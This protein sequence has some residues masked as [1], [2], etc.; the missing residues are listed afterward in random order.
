MKGSRLSRCLHALWHYLTQAGLF[1]LILVALYVGLGRQFMRVMLLHQDRLEA[2][3]SLQVGCQVHVGSAEGTWRGIQP[4]LRLFKVAL[5]L[6]GEQPF[7]TLPELIIQPE[8][9]ASL[10]HHEAR[11]ALILQHL[12]LHLHQDTEGH[13]SIDELAQ[14]PASDTEH[15]KAMI[16]IL[17]HQPSLELRDSLLDMVPWQGSV[18]QVT[19]LHIKVAG[20]GQLHTLLAD[21][22]VWQNRHDL[23]A[24]H[25]AVNMRGEFAAL[26]Q[27]KVHAYLQI[28]RVRLEDFVPAALADWKVNRV[29]GVWQIWADQSPATGR[30]VT[31][32]AKDIHMEAKHEGRLLDLVWPQALMSWQGTASHE[33]WALQNIQATLNQHPLRTGAMALLR[34]DRQWRLATGAW[35]L[36]MPELVAQSVLDSSNHLRVALLALHPQGQLKH[37]LFVFKQT[38]SGIK[39]Q[40]VEAVVDDAG[41]QPWQQLPGFSHLDMEI[42]GTNETGRIYLHHDHTELR[43]PSYLDEPVALQSLGAQ[44]SWQQDIDGILSMTA[45]VQ[46]SNEDARI[47]AALNLRME[48]IPHLSLVASME[49]GQAAATWRYTPRRVVGNSTVAWLHTAL[50]SGQ[51]V[52]GLALYEGQIGDAMDALQMNFNVQHLLLDYQPGWPALKEVNAQLSLSQGQLHLDQAQAQLWGTTLTGVHADLDTRPALMSLVLGGLVQGPAMDTLRLFRESPLRDTL[53]KAVTGWTVTGPVHGQL[54]LKIPLDDRPVQVSVTA[55]LPGNDMNVHDPALAFS[56]VHGQMHFDD[57][58]GLSGN[59]QA[60]FLQYPVDVSLVSHMDQGQLQT[61]QVQAQGKASL[62]ALATRWPGFWWDEISGDIPFGLKLAIHPASHQSDTLELNSSL[63]GMQSRLPAPLDKLPDQDLAISLVASQGVTDTLAHLRVGSRLGAAMVFKQGQLQRAAIRLG[64]VNQGWPTLPGIEV[65][66]YLESLDA[67]RWQALVAGATHATSSLPAL[68]LA[69]VDIRSMDVMGHRLHH[70]RLR[71][72]HPGDHWQVSLYSDQLSGNALIPDHP[73]D[74]DPNQIHVAHL[75][76]PLEASDH[77][78]PISQTAHWQPTLLDVDALHLDGYPD[79]KVHG[80]LY[81]EGQSTFIKDLRWSIPG[82]TMKGEL[83]WQPGQLTRWDATMDSD[84]LSQVFALFDSVPTLDAEMAHADLHIL[85]PGDPWQFD[86]AQAVGQGQL[87]LSKG[88]ILAVSRTASVSRVIGLFNFADIGR[89]LKLD[90]SDLTEKGV[91][92]DSFVLKGSLQS[93]RL[94]LQ[95]FELLGPALTA[96]GQGTLGLNTHNLDVDMGVTVPVTRVFPLAL[97][98]VAGPVVGG[99]ALAAQAVLSHPLAKLTT[100]NYHLSGSWDDP[101]VKLIGGGG[102][103]LPF[104]HIPQVPAMQPQQP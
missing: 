9:G 27:A 92:F 38:N 43:V 40:Y 85:W 48:A 26:N 61:L 33:L 101:E 23:G 65:Q 56:H 68:R 36:S 91:A 76:W 32:R 87:K 12:H 67:D 70:V 11:F 64:S 16:K 102:L 97:A 100:V 45:Q 99:A 57:S 84:D 39:I 30:Q 55:E 24:V 95:N 89:R 81:A 22:K 15:R 62:N 96:E 49:Q 71:T 3:L 34:K 72:E 60:Q 103:R 79:S 52:H 35:E 66:G 25:A 80:R 47:Q 2:F 18:V 28:P 20:W 51:V 104:R 10:W 1:L 86:L 69:Q 58:A 59:L 8:L 21:G 83:V 6:P 63:H 13:W 50:K 14:L 46:A 44:G 37:G 88:R 90:F 74:L 31:I 73:S 78:R 4:T 82:L 17:G 53:G 77:A 94:H 19:G 42:Q 54:D 75:F 93:D 5:A 7:L 29:D 98:F 41:W